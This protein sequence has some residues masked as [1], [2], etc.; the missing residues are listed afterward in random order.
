MA[1]RKRWQS[2]RVES[3][4]AR[5]TPRE[6]AQM[7]CCSRL[8]S[9]FRLTFCRPPLIRGM[10]LAVRGVQEMLFKKA[11]APEPCDEAPCGTGMAYLQ[12]TYK[13]TVNEHAWHIP[14][15]I[16]CMHARQACSSGMHDA[17]ATPANFPTCAHRRPTLCTAPST[18]LRRGMT[19]VPT[20]CSVYTLSSTP[21][22]PNPTTSTS[23]EAVRTLTA[24]Q[25]VDTEGS[26]TCDGVPCHRP[27]SCVSRVADRAHPLTP[28]CL[29]AITQASR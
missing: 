21:P 9:S 6:T 24:V 19:L 15:M 28:A 7:R 16:A 4:V 8:V 18:E 20:K 29:R 14:R 2:T 11:A 13:R 27:I 10:G 1:V 3:D 12:P 25:C 22:P 23:G 17:C 5:S 26:A